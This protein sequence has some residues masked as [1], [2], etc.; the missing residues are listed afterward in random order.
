MLF[1][2]YCGYV[3]IHRIRILP[4]NSHHYEYVLL[5]QL[6]LREAPPLNQTEYLWYM[7]KQLT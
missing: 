2:G 3:Q 7:R 6:T 1:H 5:F 4:Q